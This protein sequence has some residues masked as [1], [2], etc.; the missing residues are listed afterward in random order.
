MTGAGEEGNKKPQLVV[1]CRMDD[2]MNRQL[3]TELTG[4]LTPAFLADE[5]VQLG[6]INEVSA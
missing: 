3:R 6:F 5:L 4:E 2:K 1:Q